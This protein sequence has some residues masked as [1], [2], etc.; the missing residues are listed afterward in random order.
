MRAIQDVDPTHP[1]TINGQIPRDL[2]TIV[3][4]SI[5]RD[6]TRRYSSAKEM[7]YDLRRFL[8]NEPI[9]AKP[10]SAIDQMLKWSRRHPQVASLATALTVVVASGILAVF[11]QWQRAELEA[12]RA[13]QQS[14]AVERVA[15]MVVGLVQTQDPLGLF[16]EGFFRAAGNTSKGFDQEK[17]DRVTEEVYESLGTNPQL[18]AEILN[19]VGN[20][21]LTQGHL[22]RALPLIEDALEIRREV[23]GSKHHDSV[24]SL[25]VVAQLRHIEGREIEAL[26]HLKQIL[27]PSMNDVV[28]SE[29]VRSA[30]L[31]MAWILFDQNDNPSIRRAYEVISEVVESHRRDETSGRELAMALA[32]RAAIERRLDKTSEALASL[33]EAQQ[34]ADEPLLRVTAKM[35]QAL[36]EWKLGFRE[37]A[38]KKMKS[39]NRECRDLLGAAHPAMMYFN[40]SLATR[41]E[42]DGNVEE[43]ELLMR[44]SIEISRRAIGNKPRTARLI[45]IYGNL[46]KRRKRHAE[47]LK[48]LSE[49][50]EI[51]EQFET[52]DE[53]IASIKR[54]IADLEAK[55]ES[56]A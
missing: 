48:L 26:R 45:E 37:S 33:N 8:N 52:R 14:E 7:G 5:E 44:E 17:F 22:D 30:K 31:L 50:L 42:W 3:M 38:M 12:R 43:A 51:Y 36:A 35:I 53:K 24:D 23:L 2:E 10:A 4:K 34:Q 21:Y 16:G 18:Q 54:V 13:N 20:V 25:L 46:L 19:S 32:I 40:F 6:P 27:D 11:W 29:D 47:A 15:Q 9:R 1:R 56:A 55:M 41:H 28:D 49:A 39:A